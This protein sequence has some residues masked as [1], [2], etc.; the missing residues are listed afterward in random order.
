MTSTFRLCRAAIALVFL[1]AFPAVAAELP[2]PAGPALVTV[3]GKIAQNNR[4][5]F[6]PFRDKLFG[7]NDLEFD[8]AA[9]FDLAM[10]EGLGM[11][12]VTVRYPNWPSGHTF[13]G[14]LLKDVMAAAGAAGDK[15]LPMALDGYAAEIPMSDLEKWPVILALKMD[16][17]YMGVGG[18]GPAFV[19][20]PRDD[21][22]ALQAQDDAKWVWGVFHITVE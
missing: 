21:Y 6:E 4:E 5:P 18:A 10:L 12:T 7:V 17:Q 2:A 19:I 9:A 15:V 8:R 16:G 1:L 3:T 13:E 11:Q 22:P 14:P 20:Y